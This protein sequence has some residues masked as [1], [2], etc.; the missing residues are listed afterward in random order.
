[1]NYYLQN[2]SNVKGY[3]LIRKGSQR[4]GRNYMKKGGG[5]KRKSQSP[6]DDARG[7]NYHFLCGE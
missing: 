3:G 4:K 2:I 7:T 1:M 6:W 5:V